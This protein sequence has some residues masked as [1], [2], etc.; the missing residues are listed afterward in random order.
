MLCFPQSNLWHLKRPVLSDG[1]GG[2]LESA[3]LLVELLH[4]SLMKVEV[5]SGCSFL[6]SKV[7]FQI[8]ELKSTYILQLHLSSFLETG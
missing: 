8:S 5:I 2:G 7:A 1:S 6:Y 4:H 3:Q